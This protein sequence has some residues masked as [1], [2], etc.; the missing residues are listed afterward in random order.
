LTSQI[1]TATP[2]ASASKPIAIP[3]GLKKNLSRF[4]DFIELTAKRPFRK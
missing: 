3:M 4:M 2:A 1:A